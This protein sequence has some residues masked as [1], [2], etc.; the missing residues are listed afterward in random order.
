MDRVRHCRRLLT[1][2]ALITVTWSAGS[3]VSRASI[4]DAD[5]Q[6]T[7]LAEVSA[8]L[9]R[10]ESGATLLAADDNDSPRRQ[11]GFG[12]WTVAALATRV[13]TPMIR[14]RRLHLTVQVATPPGLP[15]TAKKLMVA[16]LKA[17]AKTDHEAAETGARV[18]GLHPWLR[19][20]K[21]ILGVGGRAGFRLRLV[22]AGGRATVAAASAVGRW[23]TG[24]TRTG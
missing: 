24:S 3:A 18:E 6:Q 20:A 11:P 13:A 10:S 9:L 15:Q 21:A 16:G 8:A 2:A 7:A 22:K 12:R 1:A 14:P 19:A 17:A 5:P 23:R 4:S